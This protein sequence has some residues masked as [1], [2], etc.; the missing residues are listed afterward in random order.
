MTFQ[1]SRGTFNRDIQVALSPL[2]SPEE[3]GIVAADFA[4]VKLGEAQQINRR[5]MGTVPPHETFVDGQKDAPLESVKSIIVFQFKATDEVASWIREQLDRRAPV[6]TGR[7]KRSFIELADDV[8]V[9]MGTTIVG[10]KRYVFVNTQLYARKI[11][12]GQSRQAPNGVFQAVASLAQA[13]FGRTVK[14]KFT[15]ITL[16]SMVDQS[17]RGSARRKADREARSP[18]ISVEPN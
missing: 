1:F 2:M 4:R 14:V 6:L 16:T 12:R 3:R 10:A 13:R 5:A 7:Y 15:Y 8:E 17:L 11:E 18:A 9:P